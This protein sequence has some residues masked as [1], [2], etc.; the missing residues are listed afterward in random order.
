MSSPISPVKV[1]DLNFIP[2]LFFD[3][4]ARVIPGYFVLGFAYWYIEI[5]ITLL[6]TPPY[7]FNDILSLIPIW[8]TPIIAY[9]L[10]VLLCI[11]SRKK[12]PKL[13]KEIEET[14][15]RLYKLTH[16]A[17]EDRGRFQKL[18]AEF[19]A[20]SSIFMGLLIL[21]ISALFA[22]SILYFVKN[23]SLKQIFIFPLILLFIINIFFMCS[24]NL[25]KSKLRDILKERLDSYAEYKNLSLRENW[26]I[27]FNNDLVKNTGVK[28]KKFDIFQCDGDKFF[29]VISPNEINNFSEKILGVLNKEE[30]EDYPTRIDCAVAKDNTVN[31]KNKVKKEDDELEKIKFAFDQFHIIEKEKLSRTRRFG[32]I[33]QSDR[34]QI[35][36]IL[37]KIFA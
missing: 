19:D 31:N 16:N 30:E 27:K 21:F 4:I 8:F 37:A 20:T 29:L 13:D 11:L 12:H 32:Q 24:I 14:A 10:A 25:W 23:I 33:I 34:S 3:L 26:D 6:T 35:L 28:I 1:S 22:F 36:D 15:Q 18:F 9:Y 5:F 17:P 2:E 7:N